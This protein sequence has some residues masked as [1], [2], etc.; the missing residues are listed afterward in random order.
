MSGKIINVAPPRQPPLARALAVLDL[1]TETEPEWATAEIATAAGLPVSTTYRIVATLESQGLLRPVG[2]GRFR[3][4]AAAVSLGHRASAGFDLRRDL[5]PRLEEVAAATRETALLSVF[6]PRRLGVL[7]ID[8][9][10]APQPLRLSLE[11]GTVVP[12]H[13]G[14]TS[15]ALL[16]FLPADVLEEALARPLAAVGPG[17]ITD[18][19]ALRAELAAIRERGWAVSREETNAGAW[20]A[21][22]PV[23]S[24]DGVALAVIGMAGPLARHSEAAEQAACHAVVTASHNSAKSLGA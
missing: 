21:A 15:K 4:G 12:L 9:V 13:A 14:A 19:A 11:I 1:F 8:R 5:H 7:C 24:R 6:E 17:T 10:E 22:A 3:L 18:P 23:L 20:G 16:A 2:A